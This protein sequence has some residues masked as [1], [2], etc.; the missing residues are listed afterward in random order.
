M[1][2]EWAMSRFDRPPRRYPV[3]SA[4]RMSDAAGTLARGPGLTEACTMGCLIVAV[5][6]CA[7]AIRSGLVEC[8]LR[9]LPHVRVRNVGEILITVAVDH[10]RVLLPHLQ[11]RLNFRERLFSLR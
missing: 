4:G 6:W 8:V 11:R 2:P 1:I 7:D 10:E 3:S 5:S 9:Q